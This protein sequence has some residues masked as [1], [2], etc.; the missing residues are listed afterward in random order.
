MRSEQMLIAI[1]LAVCLCGMWL[2]I[3]RATKMKS[4]TKLAIYVPYVIWFTLFFLSAFSHGFFGQP[5][6]LMQ[7]FFG[8]GVIIHIAAGFQAWRHG[9]PAYSQETA[10]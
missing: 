1:N 8:I 2:C 6:T 10:Q 4:H 9:A 5:A 7:V 3:C